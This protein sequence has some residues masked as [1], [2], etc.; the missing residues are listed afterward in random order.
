MSLDKWRDWSFIKSTRKMD[1]RWHARKEVN[2]HSLL[3]LCLLH[4][5]VKTT[6][7]FLLC[8]REEEEEQ[9]KKKCASESASDSKTPYGEF[10]ECRLVLSQHSQ[11]IA[12]NWSVQC[13]PSY[14]SYGFMHIFFP[15]FLSYLLNSS[16]GPCF[17][18]KRFFRKHLPSPP[19]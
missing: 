17:P 1:H 4:A 5:I 2:T 16:P 18:Q 3:F 8:A 14:Q 19:K 6:D 11:D 13:L 7:I 15:L 12:S 10:V 9:R